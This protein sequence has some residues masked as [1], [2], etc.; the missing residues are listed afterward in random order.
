MRLLT[1]VLILVMLSFG[2][3]S[4]AGEA[5]SGGSIE[6][7][8][9]SLLK[10]M[11]LQEKLGQMNQINWPWERSKA[12]VELFAEQVEK[13]RI[14]SFLSLSVLPMSVGERNELQKIAVEK[15][16]LGVPLIFGFDVIHGYRTI[17]PIPLAQSCTWDPMLVEKAASISAKEATSMGVDWT[18]APMVDIARDP[19]WGRIAEGFGEDPYL[20]SIFATA[21]VRGFQGRDLSSVRSLVA[22]LKHYVGYGAA[23]GGRDYNT[24][25]IAER[26]LREVYL[27]PFKAGVEAGAAT[28]MSAFNEISG[29]PAA[30]NRR[31]LTEILKVEWR[32]E[33]FVVSDWDS[34]NE[35]IKHG[36][37]EDQAQAAHKALTAGVDMDMVSQAYLKELPR[38][39]IE[40]KVL[41]SV[42]DEAVRR[43]LGIKLRTGLFD[44][45][46]VDPKLAEPTLLT[47]ENLQVAREVA[48]KSIVLLKNEKSL[49]PLKKDLKSLAVIGPLADNQ[50]DL[51]GCWY[52]AGRA[53]D[54]VSVLQGIR[55]KVSSDCDLIYAKGCD[56][57]GS[58]VDGFA[59]AV[60]LARKADVVILVV[61]ESKDMSGEAHSRA[62]LDLPGVQQRLVKAVHAVGK[63]VVVVLLSGRPMSVSW[64]K[65]N[66]PAI[67]LAW[68]PGTQGGNAVADCLFGDYN[69]SGKLTTSFP[70]TVGQ[71]PIYYNHKNTGRP[72]SDSIYTSKYIDVPNAPLFA[73][74]Y[75]LSY[76]TFEYSNLKVNPSKISTGQSVKV[77]ADI[78]NTGTRSGEEV[79][80]L[81]IRDLVASATRPVRELKGF[82][83]VH[84]QPGQTKTVSFTLL[85]EHLAFYD[86]HMNWVVEPGQFKVWVGPNCTEGLDGGFEVAC[87]ASRPVASD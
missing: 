76:T 10:K 56:I 11:T 54:V 37:A 58:S 20:A 71:V 18:F 32:F 44:R 84:L 62:S 17:F 64:I 38:L 66:V 25:E 52:G 26:T 8:V 65:E 35:L 14:S 21:C 19:R 80:Q 39:V 77:T 27:P 63:P 29:I 6:Q 13:G 60:R 74:G 4:R 69:P 72:A 50:G 87:R 73:F 86:V 30:A 45:P 23:E 2:C 79:A 7:K 42:V 12:K 51:L 85:P 53:D 67:M 81:Y 31:T 82:Q 78:K 48:R 68:H 47:D 57:T 36:F 5:Q 22:C 24:C 41:E 33:G 40:G 28:V 9:E 55:S 3:V 75:G 49:L 83:K 1:K 43:I 16:R 34:V 59:E 46:Y 15:S 70:R 61:G